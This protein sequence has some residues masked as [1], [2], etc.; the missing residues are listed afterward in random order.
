M[1]LTM[2]RL[3]QNMFVNI[4]IMVMKGI[5]IDIEDGRPTLFTVLIIV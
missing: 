3:Y 4:T 5:L 1:V 2:M